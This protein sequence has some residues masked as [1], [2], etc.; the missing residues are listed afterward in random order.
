MSKKIAELSFDHGVGREVGTQSSSAGVLHARVLC[1]PQLPKAAAGARGTTGSRQWSKLYNSICSAIRSVV[2]LHAKVSYGAFKLGV[3]QQDLDC[4][5][6][7]E[8][9]RPL[10]LFWI[11]VARSRIDCRT[12]NPRPFSLTRSQARSLLSMARLKSANSRICPL[13]SGR[14]R[15]DQTLFG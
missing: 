7:L 3:L 9:Y 13:I 10:R 1:Q 14:T 6:Y 8:L 15:I 5:E 11:I 4:T 2:D 12:T